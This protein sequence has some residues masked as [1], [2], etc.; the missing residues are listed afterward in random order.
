[1]IIAS[2]TG[3]IELES[4]E[5]GRE[6]KVVDDLIKKAV[7]NVFGKYYN[8]REFDDLLLTFENGISVETGTEIP[9]VEYVSQ[10]S[11]LD[12]VSQFVKRI[13]SSDNPSLIA[14]ALELMLEGLHLNRRLNRD[15]VE[16]KFV[17]RR[18]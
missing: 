9:S 13:E 18:D 15:T 2:T 4:V 1:M 3:K 16:G 6:T 12:G 14:S 17:Y 7:L 11:K 5:E 8:A 10:L